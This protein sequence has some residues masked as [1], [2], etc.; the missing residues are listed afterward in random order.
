MTLEPSDGHGLPHMPFAARALAIAGLSGLA[1]AQPLLGALKVGFFIVQRARPLDLVALALIVVVVPPAIVLALEELAGL[2]KP[3]LL[4]LVHLLAVG[5]LGALAVSQLF[6]SGLRW[7]PRSTIGLAAGVVL[8]LAYWR[9]AAIRSFSSALAI[10]P[11]MSIVS[12]LVLAP[13]AS[14][15]FPNRAHVRANAAGRATTPVVLVVF[16]E[17]P[18]NTLLGPDG[19]FDRRLFPN[20]ARFAGR[21]TWY[22]Y[23]TTPHVVTERAVPAIFTGSLSSPDSQ[24]AEWDHPHSLFTLL[25]GRY[26]LNVSEPYTQVCPR[27]LCPDPPGERFP[28]RFLALIANTGR[29][30]GKRY[31]PGRFADR[32]PPIEN[33]QDDLE[34]Q[35]AS[36]TR[37]LRPGGRPSL[38]VLHVVLPHY[39][40][41]YLPDGQRYPTVAADLNSEAT[42]PEQPWLVD[43]RYQRHVLQ[44]QYADQALGRVVRRLKA[45]GLWDRS[46]V[47]VVADHGL[48]IRPGQPPREHPT[49]DNFQDVMSVPLLLKAPGQRQAKVSRQF[50]RTLDVAPTIAQVLGVRLP[51]KVDGRSLRSRS[52]DRSKLTLYYDNRSFT[53][54]PHLFR[55]RLLQVVAPREALLASLRRRG[56]AFDMGPDPELLDRRLPAHLPRARGEV[57][58][59]GGDRLPHVSSRTHEIFARVGGELRGLHTSQRLAVAV[60]GRIDATTESYASSPGVQS[61]TAMLRPSVV[62]TGGPLTVLVISHTG[63]R[64][65]LSRLPSG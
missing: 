41:H 28:P 57:S 6:V 34:R 31:L 32:V 5:G 52:S 26:R 45:T 19:R 59:A 53:V 1:F 30:A 29:I 8:A 17:L 18:V 21:S 50:V 48:S 3:W 62:D 46:L 54:S 56:D 38:N 25:G 65:Q 55:D 42:L 11:A 24:P 39:P 10:A 40:W 61:F 64:L 60:A 36:F 2:L 4:R 44:T 33:W 22:P 43:Q 51:W 20:F 49:P 23:A 47:A 63:K 27:S 13:T 58:L 16:D 37:K 9:W 35:A 15:V 7:G 12:F 14:V